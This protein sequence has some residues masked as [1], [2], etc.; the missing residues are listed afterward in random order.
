MSVQWSLGY[1]DINESGYFDL[2]A[3]AHAYSD[4]FSGLS[5]AGKTYVFYSEGE[6]YGNRRRFYR[7]GDSPPI[8]FASTR[9]ELDI[10]DTAGN[11]DWIDVEIMRGYHTEG[12]IPAFWRVASPANPDGLESTQITIHYT[13]EEVAEMNLDS[14][15]IYFR[16][17]DSAPWTPLPSTLMPEHHRIYCLTSLLGEF[18]I[19]D[20]AIVGIEDDNVDMPQ[21]SLSQNYPNPMH[22]STKI[23]FSLPPDVHD[24]KIVIY[25]I[26]GQQVKEF[27]LPAGGSDLG[28]GEATWDGKDDNGIP[29]A[30]GIYFYKLV[31]ENPADGTIHSA[32]PVH[33]L[34]LLRDN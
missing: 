4:S 19:G 8:E 31:A 10:N 21:F 2:L 30:N 26:K 27:N 23:S 18:S 24:A 14:L 17:D 22:T 29:V 6:D 28:F 1:G 16:P 20:Q 11:S 13:A 34:L 32:L 3:G 15:A 12:F 7:G 9:L 5:L 25:N 33:K